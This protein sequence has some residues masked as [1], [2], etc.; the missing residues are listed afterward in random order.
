VDL[1]YNRIEMNYFINQLEYELKIIAILFYYEDLPQKEIGEVLKIPVGTVK[2][3]LST[4][5][6]KL[7]EMLAIGE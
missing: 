5:R 4:V 6:S 3:R 7:K 1:N 2:S